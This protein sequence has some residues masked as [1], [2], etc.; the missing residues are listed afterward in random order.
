MRISKEQKRKNIQ[1][2]FKAVVTLSEHDSF[3]NLTMKAIA[4]EAGIGEATIYNYFPKK[5]KLITGFLHWSVEEAIQRTREDD[6]DS[7]TFTEQLHTFIDNHI[8]ILE[9][10]KRFF[11][12]SV[13]SVFVNPLVLANTSVSETKNQYL[14]F[15]EERFNKSLEK[16]DFTAPPFQEFLVQLIWDFHIG[17]LYY[18]I[19]EPGKDAMK[20]T[21]LV[22]LSLQVFDEVLQSDLFNKVYG[23]AHFLFKEHILNKMLNPT[24]GTS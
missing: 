7:M 24:K 19:R 4:K 6:L 10:S 12:E 2:V 21:Q 23:V 5:E 20:T 11:R 15:V 8:E 16:G 1:S 17:V 18:W 3:D 9:P 14:S 22:D 13:E